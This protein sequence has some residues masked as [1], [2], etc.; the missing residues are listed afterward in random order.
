[1]RL[2]ITAIAYLVSLVVVAAIAFFAVL[3][4]AGPHGGV[5]PGYLEPVVL[6]LG[7]LAVLGLPAFAAFRVWKKLGEPPPN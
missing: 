2:L 4:L 6:L 3:F 1:M 5:R 7:W